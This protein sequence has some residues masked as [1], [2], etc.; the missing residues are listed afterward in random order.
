MAFAIGV[1]VG[2]ICFPIVML[3]MFPAGLVFLFLLSTAR[4]KFW[5]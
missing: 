5:R 3:I 4:S 2:F 1:I